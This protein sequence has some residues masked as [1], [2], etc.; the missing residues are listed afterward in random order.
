MSG[1]SKGQVSRLCEEIDDT[2]KGF[3]DRP[4]DGDWPYSG[5]TRPTSRSVAAGA[6]SLLPSSLRG[7][8]H[9]RPR[10]SS[11]DGDRHVRG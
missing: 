9:R 8:Q 2:V 5:S 6:S 7:R 10:L 4:I 11:W 3:L 1:I